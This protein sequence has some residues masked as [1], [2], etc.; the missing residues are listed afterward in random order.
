[1]IGVGT[2]DVQLDR[3]EYTFSSLL[4]EDRDSWGLSYL[5]H[6]RYNNESRCY[7]PRFGQGSIIGIHLDMWGGKLG[8]VFGVRL[9]RANYLS[10]VVAFYR[11]RQPLGEVNASLHGRGPL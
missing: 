6:F 8:N 3:N 9:R 11:N 4:G 2:S 5:G 10:F 1:M 7:S